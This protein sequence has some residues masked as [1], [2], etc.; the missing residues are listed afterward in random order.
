MKWVMRKSP[1]PHA[2][3]TKHFERPHNLYHKI[4]LIQLDKLCSQH[5]TLSTIVSYIRVRSDISYMQTT[6]NER[7]QHQQHEQQLRMKN[8]KEIKFRAYLIE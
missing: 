1:S 5:Y 2:P 6:K 7:R 8:G 3:N 4:T